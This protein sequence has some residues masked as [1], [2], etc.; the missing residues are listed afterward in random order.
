MPTLSDLTVIVCT[1][2]RPDKLTVALASIR[3]ACPAE[4]D[5]LVVDSASVTAETREVARDAGCRYVRSDI[6]GLSI[7]RNLGLR[8]TDRSLVVYIDDDCIAVEGWLDPILQHFADPAVGAVTGHMLDH[9]LIGEEIS[10]PGIHVFTRT[11]QGLDAGHGAIMCFRRDLV[12]QIGGFDETLGAGREL[13]GAEDLDMFCRILVEGI[14]IVYDS[15]C[16]IHH[17]N[18][19]DRDAYAQ[20]HHGYGMGLGALANKWL[21]LRPVTGATLLAVIL[22]R[23][24][25]RAIRQ[26]RDP[27]QRAAE[28]AMLAGIPRGFLAAM[29][30]PLAGSTYVDVH[31]PTPVRLTTAGGEV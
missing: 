31:P 27:R 2:N 28:R 22:K 13:A 19:R 9:T 3:A 29:R 7:A 10:R 25:H 24:I 11:I 20:L 21:R 16:V 23:T 30:L 4:V 6:K 17:V 1:R 5:I 12:L 8:S 14:H 18:T 26:V 15:S